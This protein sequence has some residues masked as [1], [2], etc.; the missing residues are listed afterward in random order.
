VGITSAG[1]GV[2]CGSFVL[3]APSKSTPIKQIVRIVTVFF[4]SLC[5]IAR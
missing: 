5:I 4:S 2:P 1:G 3:H